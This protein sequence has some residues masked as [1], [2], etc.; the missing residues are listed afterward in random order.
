MEID[1]GVSRET[2]REGSRETDK[3]VEVARETDR[4]L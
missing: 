2:D 4:G 1:R 3:E